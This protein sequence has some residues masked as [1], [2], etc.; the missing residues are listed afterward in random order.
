VSGEPASTQTAARGVLARVRGT[1]L[2]SGFV[3]VTLA[4]LLGNIFSYVLLVLAVRNLNAAD[5]SAVVTLLNLLLVGTVPTLA[6]QAVA[7]R[8]VARRDYD[9]LL[10]TT[11]VL[12]AAATV[13]G[14][15][16]SPAVATFL[17]L[18]GLTDTVLVAATLPALAAQGLCQG[19]W[20]GEQRFRA[21]AVGTFV[22]IG[23]RSGLGLLGLLAGGTATTTIACTMAGATIAAAGCLLCVPQ[24]RVRV[25]T[26]SQ[27]LKPLLVESGHASHAY[28]IFLLLCAWDLLLA[29]HVLSPADAA[30][31][32]AG[33]VIARGALWL[34]QS[35]ANVLFAS[36]TDTHR[37]QRVLARGVGAI[38]GIG[39]VVIGGAAVLSS[40]ITTIVAG[41]RYP[42]L[43]HETWLFAGL[44]SAL[45]VMQFVVVAGLAV[46]H[47]RS[48]VVLWCSIIAETVVVL[49]V[50][51]HTSVTSIVGTVF[52]INV[53]AAAVAVLLGVK[54]DHRADSEPDEPGAGRPD[55]GQISAPPRPSSDPPRR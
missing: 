28:G 39:V 49:G 18:P 47:T 11:L 45:A 51:Q 29:R 12:G 8:S 21:L 22:G 38:V 1:G 5:Y 10:A 16:V 32:A 42:A 19:I 37:H 4:N 53:V 9:G 36:L 34:P 23:G 40:I 55:G 2:A 6:L 26:S 54:A 35:V 33:S 46:R 15:A 24:L 44:G 30:T 52:A 14:L 50:G 13:L 27:R 25:S 31:Y 7:A 3:G 20:Q 43:R 48:A 41:S 17:H